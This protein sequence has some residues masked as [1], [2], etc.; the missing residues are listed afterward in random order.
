MIVRLYAFIDV[1]RHDPSGLAACRRQR[2]VLAEETTL[3]GVREM[4]TM[5]ALGHG[6]RIGRV[7]ADQWE[8]A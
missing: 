7:T 3:L 2:K 8:S 4:N 6:G 5:E 1:I